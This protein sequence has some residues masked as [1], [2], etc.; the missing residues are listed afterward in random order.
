MVGDARSY[1]ERLFEF[2]DVKSLKPDEARAA[3]IQP[4]EGEGVR[5]HSDALDQVITRTKGYPYFLQEF[6][7]QV[8]NLAGG[9]DEI[10]S[11]DVEAS[12]PIVT[13]KLDAGFFR[14]GIDRTTDMERSYLSEMA[15]LG[16]GRPYASGEVA[17]AM[18]KTTAQVGPHHDA[19][20]RRGLC[21]S[22]C[23]GVIDFTV[24]TFEKFIRRWLM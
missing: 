21:Y 3:L 24:P 5:W 11:V 6:G 7:K 13:D 16:A 12:T 9:F 23:Y 8:W 20:I 14:V 2:R 15:S 18:G 17:A 1:A 4:A 19:L 10:A 22:P